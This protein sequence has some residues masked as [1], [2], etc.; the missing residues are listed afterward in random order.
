MSP[1]VVIIYSVIGLVGIGGLFARSGLA[2][3]LLWVLAVP[4]FLLGMLILLQGGIAEPMSARE[5]LIAC[6][7]LFWPAMGCTVGTLVHC[8]RGKLEKTK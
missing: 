7:I 1:K 4:F 5:I 3:V 6:S 2:R 8:R